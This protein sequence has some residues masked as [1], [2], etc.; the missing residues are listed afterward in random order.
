VRSDGSLSAGHL[1]VFSGADST[2]SGANRERAEI[3]VT[4]YLPSAS[5][6]IQGRGAV[7]GQGPNRGRETQVMNALIVAVVPPSPVGPCPW[8]WRPTDRTVS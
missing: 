8:F 7:P 5:T 4:L 1:K 6:S 3:V 2:V